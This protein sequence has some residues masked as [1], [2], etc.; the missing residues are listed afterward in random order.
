M[1]CTTLE[2]T[3]ELLT[4]FVDHAQR[5]WQARDDERAVHSI[6]HSVIHLDQLAPIYG[7]ERRRLRVVKC[8][9]QAFRSGYHDFTIAA[10]GVEVFPRLVA[11]EHRHGF[12]GKPLASGIAELDALLGGGIAAGSSTLVLG[13]AGTG[14]SL[15]VLQFAASAVARQKSG[16]TA[17]A[18]TQVE[19]A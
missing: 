6:A 17:E 16:R 10:G 19:G 9:G 18:R 7:G 12:A 4:S 15:L 2:A 5:P 13:P 1:R 14:K 8:R 3:S 11:A